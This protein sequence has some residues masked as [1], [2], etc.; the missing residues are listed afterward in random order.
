MASHTELFKKLLSWHYLE[1][2]LFGEGRGEDFFAALGEKVDEVQSWWKAGTTASFVKFAPADAL[3]WLLQNFNLEKPEAFS[4]SQARAMADDAWNI[5]DRSG[6]QEGILT[7]VARL[8]YTSC[9]L[10]PVW[11][12][13]HRRLVGLDE[14][15][16][17][18]TLPREPDH[19]PLFL[20]KTTIASKVVPPFGTD[21]EWGA[22]WWQELNMHF[23]SFWLVINPPHSFGFRRW[24][25]PWTFGDGGR[26]D[27]V[28]AGDRVDLRRLF[29]TVKKMRCANFSCRG[30][31]FTYPG[32]YPQAQTIWSVR[33]WSSY[34]AIAVGSAGTALQWN[35]NAW[36]PMNTGVP[37]ALFSVWGRSPTDVWAV[38]LFGRIIHFDGT[39]WSTVASPT[40][41]TLTGVVGAGADVWACGTNGALLHW[42]GTAWS[43]IPPLSGDGLVEMFASGTGD[44]WAVGQ[45][46]VAHHF[47]GA[48]WATTNTGT[49]QT[50]YSIWGRSGSD[51]WAGGDAGTLLRWNGTAWSAAASPTTSSIS[52]IWGTADGKALAT[53]RPAT[54][55]G[56]LLAYDGATW[57]I[58]DPNVKTDPAI[59]FGHLWGVHG[60]TAGNFWAVG[61]G[62]LWWT[63]EAGK[64]YWNAPWG[65]FQ[66]GDGTR[67]NLNYA[68]KRLREPWE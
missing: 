51:I 34:Q 55:Q 44:V 5:W 53:A 9:A 16:I 35:G 27:G 63:S 37:E 43:V 8:G 50:L 22:G 67:Y 68:M 62:G 39:A 64:L 54:R 52:S 20:P 58:A 11:Q 56:E 32:Y 49:T 41:E 48:T 3:A 66:W 21:P 60:T 33:S 26:W 42:N 25:D 2:G 4:E 1:R 14:I 15:R 45:N 57:R 24:G 10:L 29:L 61:D 28:V 19:N 36:I 7:E 23:S 47:D 65:G 6:G 59:G 18:P 38:G 17:Q 40:Q 30:V 31:V 12:W 46:G 13:Q